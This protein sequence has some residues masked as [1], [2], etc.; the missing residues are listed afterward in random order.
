MTK[1]VSDGKRRERVIV[2]T[3][4]ESYCDDKRRER[5]VMT[6]RERVIVMTREERDL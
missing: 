2:M 6:K 1:R 5:F 4:R 3:K